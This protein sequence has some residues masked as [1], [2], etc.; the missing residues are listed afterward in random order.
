MNGESGEPRKLN[1]DEWIF[2]LEL[3]ERERVQLMTEI[4][5]TATRQ[6]REELRRRLGIVEGL[7]ERL[8]QSRAA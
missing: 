3:L 6:Y 2:V 1:D 8:V 7:L 4:S 5:H